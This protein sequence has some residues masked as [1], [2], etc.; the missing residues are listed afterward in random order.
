GDGAWQQQAAHPDLLPEQLRLLRG[1]G[2]RQRD[3][4]DRRR[5]ELVV[6]GEHGR[7]PDLRPRVPD[8]LRLLRD[9]HLRARGPD[10]ER[11]R[12]LAGGGPRAGRQTRASGP[13][14]DVSET[15]GPNPFAGLM[16]ISCSD[17]NTCVATG[18]YVVP[19][20]QTIPSPDPPIITTTNGG[21]TWS[22][23]TSNAG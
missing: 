17:A 22:L 7:E 2:P 20:G 4:V 14:V 16:S 19:N 5:P 21:A 1:R 3:E 23:Q 12:H 10:N 18:L 8:P 9:R 6:A 13:G 11:R 15:G